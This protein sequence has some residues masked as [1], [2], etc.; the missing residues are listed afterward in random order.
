[1]ALSLLTE[2]FRRIPTVTRTV[3]NTVINVVTNDLKPEE[4][5]RIVLRLAKSGRAPNGLRFLEQMTNVTSVGLDQVLFQMKDVR[6]VCVLDNNLKSVLQE[7]AVKEKFDLTQ[8][9]LW[10]T[11]I[12]SVEPVR[13]SELDMPER[14]STKT[15]FA[16]GERERAQR[17]W[18]LWG[19]R[20]LWKWLNSQRSCRRW[21]RAKW[22]ILQ[23]VD[24]PQTAVKI[25]VAND[26]RKKT[27]KT[28]EYKT[29]A[30]QSLKELDA[31]V[32][33]LL[34]GGWSLYGNPYLI[35][36]LLCQA[37]TRSED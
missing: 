36:K 16:S 33:K 11:E 32:N 3:T 28:I 1:M 14:L 13:L 5:E 18:H 12:L 23:P 10:H 24:S 37:M 22:K 30:E 8:S 9:H 15:L 6:T 25:A 4:V 29:I 35:Q 26:I 31:E 21:N 27:V 17:L 19:Q 34:K 7:D 2:W 20:L